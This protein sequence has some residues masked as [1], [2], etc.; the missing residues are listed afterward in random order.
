MV[1][2]LMFQ[3]FND[4]NG[5]RVCRYSLTVSL[6]SSVLWIAGCGSN[7]PV[8]QEPAGS[9]T[10]KVAQSED[11]SVGFAQDRVT[12][13]TPTAEVLFDGETLELWEIPSFGG[14]GDV[15]VQSGVI[16]LPEGDPVTA[17]SLVESYDLPTANY[18]VTVEAKRIEG[19]DFFATVT[20]PVKDAF[21]SLV[22]G[23]WGGNLVGLSSIDGLDASENETRRL[24]EFDD[25]RWYRIRIRVR[26]ENI[27]AWIDDEQV[28]DQN[29]KGKKIS[30]RGDSM[31][32]C[33]PLGIASFITTAAIRKIE[34]TRLSQTLA[35]TDSQPKESEDD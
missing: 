4:V 20:F 29:T 31:I 21:C 9:A 26:K 35:A 1:N 8:P 3:S 34:L 16:M 32:P 30:L 27:S 23:G 6:L 28:V 18:E 2:Q 24:I 14:E 25:D 22:V 11:A 33:R 5:K 12:E 19:S 7:N 10:A 17:I 15:S 13:K